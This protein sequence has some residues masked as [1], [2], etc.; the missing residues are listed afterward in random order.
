[1][2]RFAIVDTTTNKVVNV[3]NYDTPPSNPPPGFEPGFIAVQHNTVGP[4]WTYDGTQLVAPVVELPRFQIVVTPRQIRLA[5]T[6]VGVREQVE[7]YVKQAPIAVRDSW[8][9]STQLKQ[10]DPMVVAC[11]VALGKTQAEL[12]A[13]FE[14]AATL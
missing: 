12:D 3:I 14:L 11:M 4:D 7:E 6:Q 10:N 1:M 8:E 5:M 2:E 9:Y 13:L